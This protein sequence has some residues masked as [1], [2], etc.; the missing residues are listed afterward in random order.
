MSSGA[1]RK[2]GRKFLFLHFRNC[3]IQQECIPVGCVPAARRPYSGVC[4]PGGGL[5]GPGGFCLVRGGGSAWSGGKGGS[6]WSGGGSPLVRGGLPGL[7][8]SPCPGGFSLPGE[9]SLVDRITDT[10][11]NITLATTSLRPVMIQRLQRSY[12]VSMLITSVSEWSESI[13][14]KH[15]FCTE[16]GTCTRL[17]IHFQ[18]TNRFNLFNVSH[19]VEKYNKEKSESWIGVIINTSSWRNL[20]LKFNF[21]AITS[22]N[23]IHAYYPP[24]FHD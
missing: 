13:V 4:F 7:G 21:Y 20:P 5:P 1:S 2:R 6:P 22:C 15:T 19:I 12:P 16:W 9:P 14:K 24:G 23:H 3:T 10:C 18:L 8:G 17:N 11:K